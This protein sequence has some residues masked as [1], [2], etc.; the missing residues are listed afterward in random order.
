[1]IYEYPNGQEL[2]DDQRAYLETNPYQ[3]G[4]FFWDAPL[5]KEPS[6]RNYALRVT[7]GTE[8]LLALAVEPY[9]LMLFGAPAL[10]PE[11]FDYLQARDL[12]RDNFLCG[13]DA[14][15]A[16]LAYAAERYGIAYT[17]ALA[18]D[19][20]EATEETE[21]DVTG[22]EIPTEADLDELVE[23]LR[24][25]VADCG[26][27]DEVYPE[28]ER[29]RLERYRVLR[30]DGRIVAMCAVSSK[31]DHD[32]KI[33]DVYTRPEYRGQGLARIVTNNAKNEILRRGHIATLNVDKKNPISNHLYRSL[34]FQRVFSQGEYRKK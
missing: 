3:A 18:M 17:E 20:M 15:D 29:E 31:N 7:E 21:P 2:L 23:C 27:L 5:L 9:D 24:G 33:L 28:T 1:M 22:T 13:E 30:R 4:F 11:L 16:L 8:T 14:G 12:Y 19:F 34:G 10:T 26:L 32:E 25:F 6:A